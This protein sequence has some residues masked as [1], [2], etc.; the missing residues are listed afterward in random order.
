MSKNKL[1]LVLMCLAWCLAAAS[2]SPPPERQVENTLDARETALN[3]RDVDAY[4][5]LFHPD[6]QYRSDEVE[7]VTSKIS[8][9]FNAYQSIHI[10]T[11]NRRV[12]FEQ[13]G[14]VARVVQQFRLVT[15]DFDGERKSAN[16]TEHF[17]LKRQRSLFRS[18]FLFYEGLGV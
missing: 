15:V 4:A 10:S 17:L 16:G 13:D 11:D 9:R 5:A 7:T 18:E 2:C 12:T 1:C 14:N 6:Y 8:K 3:T